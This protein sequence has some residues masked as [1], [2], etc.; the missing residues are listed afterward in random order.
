MS[1]PTVELQAPKGEYRVVSV[2]TFSDEDYVEG[3]YDTLAEALEVVEKE[4]GVMNKTH[5]YD[6]RGVHLGEGGSY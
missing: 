6:D 5:C 2:D 1:L 3:D 4:G